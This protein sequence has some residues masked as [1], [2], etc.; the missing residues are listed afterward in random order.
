MQMP[1]YNENSIVN[2]MST[3][4]THF[5]VDSPYSNLK[6]FQPNE[7]VDDETIILLIIDGLGY[8]FLEEH[9]RD[10]FLLN[11]LYKN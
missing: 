8:N 11:Y 9:E 7:L 2:L 10:S 5:G 1:D 3:I 4:L 6:I